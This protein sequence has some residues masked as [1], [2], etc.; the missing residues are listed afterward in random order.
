MVTVTCILI[1]ATG[2]CPNCKTFDKVEHCARSAHATPSADGHKVRIVPLYII[3]IHAYHGES[4]QLEWD[5]QKD[6]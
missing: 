1:C 3:C 4:D 6:S 2:I 5:K